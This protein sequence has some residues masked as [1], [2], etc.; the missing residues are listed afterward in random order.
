MACR[1]ATVLLA[2]VCVPGALAYGHIVLPTVRSVPQKT[3]AACSVRMCDGG[4]DAPAST[5]A[6]KTAA[7]STAAA[8]AVF[9]ASAFG[10]AAMAAS[11]SRAMEGAQSGGGSSLISRLGGARSAWAS[12]S[13]A[14]ATA[15]KALGGPAKKRLKQALKSK[16]AKVPVFMVTNEGGSPFLNRLSSGD[17]SALMFIFPGEAQ[18]MLDGVLKA[19]NGASSGAKVLPT[20]LDRAFKLARLAPSPSGLRDQYSNRELTMVW[21]FAPHTEEQRAATFLLAKTRKGIT[22]PAIPG[23]MVEGLVMTKRGKEVAPLFLSKKDCDAALAILVDNG[24]EPGNVVVYDALGVL[25]ELATDIEAGDP[26]AAERVNGIEIVPPSE[27]LDF[28]EQLKRD[29]PKLQA[30]VVPPERGV[31]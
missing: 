10:G 22:A 17:Q 27:S 5:S 7:R 13:A 9:S 16:L 19:P 3:N 26:S 31:F 15:E 6:L 29:R 24:E 2:A 30:K 8:F 23:Y 18:K 4:E 20:N 1:L 11:N 14:T 21:Q 25:L 12:D 28:R